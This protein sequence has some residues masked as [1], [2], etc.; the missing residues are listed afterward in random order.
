MKSYFYILCFAM[1][2]SFCLA[3]KFQMLSKVIMI[4]YRGFDPVEM[5]VRYENVFH[6][7]CVLVSDSQTFLHFE[8]SP[9]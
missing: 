4:S 8:L 1:F 6:S 5:D 3:T 9:N 2:C 7:D